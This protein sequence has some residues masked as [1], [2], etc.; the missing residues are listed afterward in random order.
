MHFRSALPAGTYNYAI[1]YPLVPSVLSIF[2]LLA[3]EESLKIIGSSD[4]FDYGYKSCVAETVPTYVAF[5]QEVFQ[6]VF[7]ILLKR[8]ASVLY[9]CLEKLFLL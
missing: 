8:K 1:Y 5:H 6:I 9:W 4:P 3:F 7:P 2:L